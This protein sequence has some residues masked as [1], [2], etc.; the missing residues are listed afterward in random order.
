[1]KERRPRTLLLSIV[2][3]LGLIVTPAGVDAQCA[4]TATT[5]TGT[6]S[7]RTVV[8]M[9]INRVCNAG[10]GMN[11]ATC[12][13]NAVAN[14]MTWS[15]MAN[16]MTAV[17]PSCTWNCVLTT[18]CILTI[19]ASDGLPVELMEFSVEPEVGSARDETSGDEASATA[20]SDAT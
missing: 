19:D 18:V 9:G 1:M 5:V 11:G 8:V 4:V 13:P 3:G 10:I 12:F 7:A 17:S 15:A 14:A 6:P 16:A 20:D 2:L